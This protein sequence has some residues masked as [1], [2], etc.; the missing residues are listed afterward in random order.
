MKSSESGRITI[1]ATKPLRTIKLLLLWAVVILSALSGCSSRKSNENSSKLDEISEIFKSVPLHP[2]KV[3]IET[4]THSDISKA[5][6]TKKYKSEASYDEVK[7]FYIE[8][9]GAQGWH[10]IEEDELKDRGRYRGEF[11]LHFTRDEFVLSVQFAGMRRDDL[12]WNYALRL[13]YPA[14]WK[15]KI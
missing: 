13:A 8:Q 2:S 9:L 1:H 12:G 11:V 14:D 7:Q 3:E 6:I 15:V 5:A 10:L 4:D